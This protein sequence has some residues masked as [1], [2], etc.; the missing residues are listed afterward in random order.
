MSADTRTVTVIGAGIVGVMIA[1]R[2][3]NAGATVTVVDSGEIAGG[4]TGATFSQ[5]NASYSGYWRYFD[6]RWAGMRAY[7]RMAAEGNAPWWHNVGTLNVA[8]TGD[9]F[10]SQD[11]HVNSLIELGYPAE[12]L[13]GDATAVEPAFAT[14]ESKRIYRYPGEGWVDAPAMTRDFAERAS[15]LGATF[16]TGDAVTDILRDGDTV[17]GVRL[18]SGDTLDSDEVIVCAGRWT[19]ELLSLTGEESRFVAEREA[20]G[21]P[22]PGLLVITEPVEGSVQQVASVD[23]ISY[24]P[25]D[26]GR[27]MVWSP[28]EDYQLG[29]I[30]GLDADQEAADR[31]GQALLERSAEFVPA[32]RN[33]RMEQALITARAL[34]VDGSPIIGRPFGLN[35][36]Y[37]VFAH[38]A[39]T[40]APA[41]ADLV[42]AETLHGRDEDA[43]AQFRP[44]RIRADVSSILTTE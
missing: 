30:G 44:D 7:A 22:V 4:T 9:D 39:V 13:H 19:D 14:F 26:G 23:D 1:E 20:A 31:I 18:A 3:A 8:R 21:T 37:M 29:D 36:L 16:R 2:L 11:A 28:T 10:A 40:I 27:T 24:R 35:G 6:L 34:P 43:L 17:T 32:L 25:H 38:A 41:V 42:T 15:L 5:A 12:R 33:A